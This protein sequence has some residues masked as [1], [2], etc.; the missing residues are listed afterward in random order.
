MSQFG[1]KSFSNTPHDTPSKLAG[2]SS[3][4]GFQTCQPKKGTEKQEPGE[5]QLRI[6]NEELI[7][8]LP[9]ANVC[10]QS[11]QYCRNQPHWQQVVE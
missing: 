5:I 9:M 3:S 2:A 4:A 10:Q 1:S 7:Q 11:H 8:L 6:R